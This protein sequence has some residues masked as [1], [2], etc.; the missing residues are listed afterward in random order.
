MNFI[1]EFETELTKG[2]KTIKNNEWK[3]QQLPHITIVTL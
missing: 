2:F 3:E 1:K